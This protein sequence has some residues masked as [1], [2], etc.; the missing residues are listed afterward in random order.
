MNYKYKI[1]YYR[2]FDFYLS[3]IS[4]SIFAVQ[5]SFFSFLSPF[6]DWLTWLQATKRADVKYYFS[7]A[8]HRWWSRYHTNCKLK[9]EPS[10]FEPATKRCADDR[11]PFPSHLYVSYFPLFWT[12]LES[13]KSER[14]I[15]FTQP[16]A[17]ADSQTAEGKSSGHC[18]PVGHIWNSRPVVVE[19]EQTVV[20]QLARLRTIETNPFYLWQEYFTASS[21]L[22]FVQT[23]QIDGS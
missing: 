20:H 10:N 7:P 11:P 1:L 9:T 16:A 19:R 15:V 18:V 14:R 8:P 23:L 3:L 13:T 6:F 21:A 4:Y 22:C 2:V 17:S 12:A 5:K